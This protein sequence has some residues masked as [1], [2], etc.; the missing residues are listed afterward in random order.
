MNAP[1]APTASASSSASSSSS[2]WARP[3]AGLSPAR[4]RR[5]WLLSFLLPILAWSAV[6]YVPFIWHPMIRVVDAGDI[7]W[8]TPGELA[9]G[10]DIERENAT[11]RASGGRPA[12]GTRANPVFLPAPHQV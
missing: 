7:S 9:P 2:S 5:L 11:V 1:A 10:A 3:L 6:S 12:T 4:A 8:L